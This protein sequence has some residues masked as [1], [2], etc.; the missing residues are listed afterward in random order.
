M[1]GRFIRFYPAYTA[2]L[3]LQIPWRRLLALHRQISALQAEE[4][5]RALLAAAYGANPGDR[6]KTLRAYSQELEQAIGL[7]G[8]EQEQEVVR[9]ARSGLSPM[10][11][12]APAGEIEAL[13][14][15]QRLAEEQRQRE[16]AAFER[17]RQ[18]PDQ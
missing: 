17:Q 3:A 7:S 15:R 9:L 13:M 10:I 1:I 18:A 8:S 6:G 12:T 4:Q 16:R 14:A 11:Q 2:E 5:L